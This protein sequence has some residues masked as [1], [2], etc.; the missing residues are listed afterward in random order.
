VLHELATNAAKYGALSAA[1]AISI[2][3]SVEQ[4]TAGRELTIRWVETGGPP[5]KDPEQRGFGTRFL[6]TILPRELGGKV[7]L[8]FAPAGLSCT[9]TCGI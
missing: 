8:S 5:V 9:I 1:G 3:W 7:V 4:G 6:E 2:G